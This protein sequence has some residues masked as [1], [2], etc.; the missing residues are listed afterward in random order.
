MK[1]SVSLV[2]ALAAATSIAACGGTRAGMPDAGVGDAPPSPDGG[3]DAMP[4]ACAEVTAPELTVTALPTHLAGDLT[5][6]GADLTAPSACAVS[7]APFGVQSAGDD[8]VIA[9]TSLTP[10]VDYVVR[11]VASADLSFY[12]ITGCSSPTGPASRECMLYEDATTTGAE[13]GHFVAPDGPVWLVLDYYASQPPSDGSWTLDVYPSQCTSDAQCGGTTPSCLD[14]RCVGCSSSFDCT[15]PNKPVCNTGSHVCGAGP[16]SCTGDDAPP[17]ENRDDGPAGARVL[18]PDGQGQASLNGHICSAPPTELDYVAFTVTQPGDDWELQLDWASSADLDLAILDAKGQTMG[19]SYYDHPEDVVLT[20]LPAGTYYAAIS[21]F[22]Q[23][24]ITAST[25]YTL[26]TA[27]V[28]D[29]CTGAADC[30]AEYRNQIYRGDCAGGACRAIDGGSALGTGAACDSVSD[31]ASGSSC[32]SF[33]F[34]ANAD[35][36]DVCGP[37][38]AHDSD[39]GAL[40]PGFVCTTYLQQN[41]CVAK[42][43]ND[44]Q[45][46]V[47]VSTVPQ[48][49]PWAR[50]SCD[51]SS[52][53]CLP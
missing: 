16:D 51:R 18:V 38:C 52:G 29:A 2:L 53:R 10:G 31:C 35:T 7:D 46:P 8:E 36:R 43:T 13:V 30:A 34:T 22:S 28:A 3:P 19:L 49:P 17:I 44:A 14:G 23:Q 21:Q 32:S 5:D 45:C 33:F 12:V 1:R 20:Y 42:C 41:F 24:P 6:A 40:G 11:L 47:S 26:R 4:S 15:D 37:Y 50:L 39:C 9:L 48:T 27:R 25:A